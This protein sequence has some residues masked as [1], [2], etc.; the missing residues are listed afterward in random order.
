M[1]F[2]A[3]AFSLVTSYPWW[4]IVFCL[5]AGFLYAW[6]LY[7]RNGLLP[8]I[9]VWLGRVLFLCRFLVVS[10]L[11]FLLLSPMVKRTSREVEK[12]IVI[13]ALD[14]SQSI[15]NSSD[16]LQRADLIRKDMEALRAELTDICEL[17]W[18]AF[19]DHTREQ[20]DFLFKDKLSNFSDLYQNLDALYAN[21]NVGAIVMASDGLYNEGASPVYGPSR[22]KVPVYA[23]GLG[24]TTVRR[25]V[26]ISAVSHNKTAFLGNA[27]PLEVVADARQASGA[28]TVLTIEEDSVVL[29]NRTL[30]IAGNIMHQNIPFLIQAKSKGMHRYKV[31]LSRIEGEVTYVNNERDV[32]IEVLENKQRILVLASAPHPD[33][34]ALRS[35]L[36]SSPNYEVIVSNPRDFIG[37]FS[38]YSLAVLHGLP[39]ATFPLRSEWEKLQNASVP[40]WWFLSSNTDLQA[41]SELNTLIR[42]TNGNGQLNDVLPVPQSAFSL[43]SLAPEAMEAL[44]GCPPLKSPFGMYNAKQEYYA[45]AMQKIGSVVTQF[46][47]LAFGESDGIKSAVLCGEGIWRWRITDFNATSSHQFSNEWVSAVVQY[48]ATREV[49]SPFRVVVRNSFRENEKLVFDARLVNASEQLINEPEVRLVIRN[50]EGREFPF[51]MTR[52]SNAYTLNTSPFPAGNYTYKAEV[53]LGDQVYNYKGAFSVTALQVETAITVADHALLR[54]LSGRSGGAFFLPGQA[55]DLADA[56]RNNENLKSISYMHRKL[57]DLVASPWFFAL[58]VFLLSL[59]WFIRK[60]S[61][62]Y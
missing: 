60:R 6:L 41:F 25:D 16:S 50:S 11:A 14:Q 34:A 12:P 1:Y 44:K 13:V 36:E 59:E 46:P 45:L 33:I 32:F 9:P 42:V 62:S 29:F 51:T 23:I 28:R 48:L 38:D 47:L 55:G 49:K 20:P 21:R 10:A 30:E 43:F 22:L 2:C 35:A 5:A 8:E 4:F 54:S 37:R 61:G 40:V 31:R 39:S 53:K 19:G 52:T 3:V 17:K 27:F 18:Y 15:L 24:D 26:Y 56:I 58:L 57:E 7:R